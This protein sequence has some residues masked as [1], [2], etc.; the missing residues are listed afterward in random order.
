M[1]SINESLMKQQT[2]DKALENQTHLEQ[3]STNKIIKV[4]DA[5]NNQNNIL[6]GSIVGGGGENLNSNNIA[7]NNDNNLNKDK[8]HHDKDKKKIV[9]YNV[10]LDKNNI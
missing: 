7:T 1:N 3:L 9:N 8:T 5:I 10:D 2:E 6:S 4:E